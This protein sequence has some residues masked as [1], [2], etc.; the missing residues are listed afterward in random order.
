[1]QHLDKQP[2]SQHKE[3][4]EIHQHYYL[5]VNTQKTP[6]LEHQRT[7]TDK[8]SDIDHQLE[9]GKYGYFYKYMCVCLILGIISTVVNLIDPPKQTN[10]EP[11]SRNAVLVL[12][13][14]LLQY[15][16]QILAFRQKSQTKATIA[17]VLFA[18]NSLFVI[19]ST[20]LIGFAY[21]ILVSNPS[22]KVHGENTEQ[23]KTIMLAALIYMIIMCLIQIFVNLHGSIRVRGLLKMRRLF[24]GR[25]MGSR[26]EYL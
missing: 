3:L 21:H 7:I 15:V 2:A 6:L 14:Y 5:D 26:V 24:E 20:V 23:L 11:S 17:V 13:G 8:I 25:F 18:I 22:I 19:M 16:F 9:F 12:G 1:M 10:G 4:S